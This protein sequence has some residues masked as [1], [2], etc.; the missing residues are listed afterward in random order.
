MNTVCRKILITLLVSALPAMACAAETAPATGPE[1]IAPAKPAPAAA[2]VS[3]EKKPEPPKPQPPAAAAPQKSS[4]PA[5]SK[6]PIRIG[7]VDLIRVS[8]DSEPGK[9]G[10]ARL[11]ER[12]KKFQ[13]QI[14][15]KRKQLD[16]QR[17]AIEAKLPTLTPQQREAKAKEFQKK[18]EEYQKLLQKADGELQEVQQE[19]SRILYE[20]IEQA[21]AVYGKANGL[22]VVT[23]KRDLLYQAD[24]VDGQDITEGIVKLVNEQATKK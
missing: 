4:E 19:Q 14:E 9:A 12:K 7:Y 10:Q 16:K 3:G 5:V 20:K 13:T 22:A 17:A 6:P 1:T 8:T 15:S 11:T 18:V 2:A 23:V 24:G 21:S